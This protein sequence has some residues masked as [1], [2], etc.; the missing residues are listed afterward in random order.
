MVCRKKKTK[1]RVIRSRGRFSLVDQRSAG[2]S[3]RAED[4]VSYA[5]FLRFLNTCL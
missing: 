5:D 3:F 2:K 1:G 4:V